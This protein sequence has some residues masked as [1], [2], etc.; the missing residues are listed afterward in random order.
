MSEEVQKRTSGVARLATLLGRAALELRLA[1]HMISTGEVEV[2]G[3]V[4]AMVEGL[5]R[6][7]AICLRKVRGEGANPSSPTDL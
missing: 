3:D 5:R 6:N 1:G 7:A 2:G 4:R